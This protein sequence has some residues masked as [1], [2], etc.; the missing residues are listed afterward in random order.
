MDL[1]HPMAIEVIADQ[2]LKRDY[3]TRVAEKIVGANFARAFNDI[4]TT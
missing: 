4:W 1:D 2:L 3:P